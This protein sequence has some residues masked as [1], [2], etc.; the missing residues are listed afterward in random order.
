MHGRTRDMGQY[1]VN[2]EVVDLREDRPTAASLKLAAGSPAQ[3]WVMA[4]MPGGQVQKLNDNER[5]PAE[6]EEL[7]IVPAFTYGR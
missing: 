2:G 6:A 3:D 5:L 7:S 1:V 4:T